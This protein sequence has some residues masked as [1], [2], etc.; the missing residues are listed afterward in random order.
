MSL[1]ERLERIKESSEVVELHF[2]TR[3]YLSTLTSVGRDFLEFDVYDTENN[4]ISHN[5]VP[6]SL[7]TNIVTMSTKRNREKYEVLLKE[8]NI[9]RD[10]ID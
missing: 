9:S 7:L 6:T 5:I 3:C 2:S 8:E 10:R 1:L 4:I